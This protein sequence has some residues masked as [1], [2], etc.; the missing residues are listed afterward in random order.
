MLIY[1]CQANCIAVASAVFKIKTRLGMVRYL[2]QNLKQ[3]TVLIQSLFR[4]NKLS[5]NVTVLLYCTQCHC[6]S[7]LHLLLHNKSYE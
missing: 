7:A 2:F 6:V 5:S 3:D 1:C 4:F